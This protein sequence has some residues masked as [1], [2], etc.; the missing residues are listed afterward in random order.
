MR[1]DWHRSYNHFRRGLDATRDPFFAGMG[2]GSMSV[3]LFEPRGRDM[4]TPHPQD[5]IYIVRQGKGCIEKEGE[6]IAVD[7]GDVIFIEAG[8]HHRFVEFSDDFSV[9]VVF[10]GPAGGEGQ[11]HH[12]DRRDETVRS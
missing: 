1:N 3:E 11:D 10:Y 7:A 9:W 12:A 5:E 6:V 4:Q 8:A 2:H